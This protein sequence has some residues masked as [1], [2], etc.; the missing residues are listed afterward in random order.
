[1]V[2]PPVDDDVGIDLIINDPVNV[3]GVKKIG[4]KKAPDNGEHSLEI[5][6]EMGFSDT[7][8]SAF[9]DNGVI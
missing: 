4:A 5:L 6:S 2:A 8:I 1:M 3:E 7:E 9:Q